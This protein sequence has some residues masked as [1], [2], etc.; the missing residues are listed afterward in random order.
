MRARCVL[1]L[2][3]FFLGGLERANAANSGNPLDFFKQARSGAAQEGITFAGEYTGEVFG[4]IGGGIKTGATYDGLLKLALQIDLGRMAGWNG[5][6]IYGSMLYPHG[7]GLTD[8][9]TG[10][11]NRL[12]SIDAYDSVRLFELWFQQQLWGGQFSIRI[13]QMSADSEFF[14]PE[15]SSLF[16]NS[17]FGTFPTISFGTALP[18]YPVGGLGLRV[19]YRPTSSITFRAAFFDSSPGNQNLDDKHGTLFHLNPN[20]GVLLIAEAAYHINPTK[21]NRG[22]S[23]IYTLGGYY[24][25]K[26]FTGSFVQPKH[27]AN[28]GLYAIADQVVYRA[29]PYVDEKSSSRGLSVFSSCAVAPGDR[30]LVSF[31]LDGGLNYIG[32]VPGRENDISGLAV[33]YTKIGN[34]VVSNGTVVHSG[35]ETVIEASYRIQLTEHLY[36]QPDVQC[37]LHPGAFGERPNT[38]VGGLRFDFTF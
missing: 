3:V 30:N 32:L 28:G 27:S 24:D 21:T 26:R 17:C 11:F 31:Y 15:T 6:T 2:G 20:G 33:S 16:I 29:E 9:F 23:G 1:L 38:L 22:F 14:Q 34:D 12:S 5:A 4:N 37:I 10:D 18:I 7:Q 36:L 35:H 13:G 19:D 8:Q 25:S